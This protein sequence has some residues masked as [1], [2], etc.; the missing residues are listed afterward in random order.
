[1]T[2]KAF[3]VGINDYPY[4]GSDLNGC[5]NDAH[6]WAKLL[7]EHFDFS[8]AE[9]KVITDAEAKKERILGGI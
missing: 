6:A 8:G 1:M 2:K 3:C 4:E 9:V 5:V 7:I